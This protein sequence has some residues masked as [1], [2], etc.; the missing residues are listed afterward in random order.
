MCPRTHTTTEKTIKYPTSG[1][2]KGKTQNLSLKRTKV[3]SVQDSLDHSG[4]SLAKNILLEEEN[5]A[6]AAKSKMC[7]QEDLAISISL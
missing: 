2:G 7:L 6:A 1:C 5:E 3:V 4:Q